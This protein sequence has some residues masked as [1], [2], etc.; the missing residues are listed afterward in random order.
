MTNKN[1]Y[2][3]EGTEN[4]KHPYSSEL[5]PMEETPLDGLNIATSWI[6]ISAERD[7]GQGY[8]SWTGTSRPVVLL[9]TEGLEHAK[10]VRML[11]ERLQKW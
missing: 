2:A 5:I 11:N 6:S 3:A 7:D 1:A 10:K 9:W 8:V 4:S